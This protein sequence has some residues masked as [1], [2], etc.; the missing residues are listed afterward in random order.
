MSKGGEFER[1]VCK[2][3]SLW[4]T[5][6]K[7][8]DIFWRTAGSGGRA[9]TRGKHGKSTANS[10]GDITAIDPIGQPLLDIVT[11]ELK[12]GYSWAPALHELI[13]KPDGR[14]AKLYKQWFKQ[15]R[16]SHEQAGSFAWMII[17]KRDRCKAIV[18]MPRVFAAYISPLGGPSCFTVR[19]LG[20]GIAIEAYPLEDFINLV[21]PE[22]IKTLSKKV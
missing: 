18:I 21:S 5:H 15:A 11:L 16:Q 19:V 10:D 3:L 4:W 2:S 9:T 20:D 14:A 12:R 17:H 7:R 8:D 13:D 1:S 22:H 6:G